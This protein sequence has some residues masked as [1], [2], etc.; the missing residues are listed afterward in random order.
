MQKIEHKS[1]KM[2]MGK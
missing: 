1:K 2:I